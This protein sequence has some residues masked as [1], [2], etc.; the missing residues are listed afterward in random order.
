[1]YSF[2]QKFIFN[3]RRSTQFL[4]RS[5]HF[6]K[7]YFTIKYIY[8]PAMSQVLKTKKNEKEKITA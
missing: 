8:E 2:K 7:S 4:R 6:F 5:T 1:M 3:L